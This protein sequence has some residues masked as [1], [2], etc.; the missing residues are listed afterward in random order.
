ML[1]YF[2]IPMVCLLWLTSA[3]QAEQTVFSLFSEYPETDTAVNVVNLAG[4]VVARYPPDQVLDRYVFAAGQSLT[5]LAPF[6]GKLMIDAD[7]NVLAYVPME[8]QGYVPSSEPGEVYYRADNSVLVASGI[9]ILLAA[10]LLIFAAVRYLA[11]KKQGVARRR[12]LHCG[13]VGEMKSLFLQ[14]GRAHV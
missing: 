1:K 7:N 2:I 4:R 14:I 3:A 10:P 11:F 9:A 6:R 5:D 8:E 13:F 12:C